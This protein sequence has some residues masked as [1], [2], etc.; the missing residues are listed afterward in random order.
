MDLFTKNRLTVITIVVLLVLNIFTITMLWIDKF[1]DSGFRKPGQGREN[2]NKFLFSELNLSQEQ[3]DQFR[4]ARIKHHQKSKALKDE[5]FRLKQRIINQVFEENPDED[6]V[7]DLSSRIGELET[8]FEKEIYSHFTQLKNICNEDQVGKF[9]QIFREV[10]TRRGP[11]G[12]EHPPEGRHRRKN[13]G[14]P[15]RR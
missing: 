9:E 8:E 5:I 4:E 15:H 12:M 6:L 2:I 3:S 14:Q 13:R 7:E 11:P 1:G 10:F